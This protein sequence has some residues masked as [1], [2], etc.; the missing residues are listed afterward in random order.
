MRLRIINF[1]KAHPLFVNMA[2]SIARFCLR[3]WGLFVPVQ[4]K[5]MLFASYGGRKFDDS[6]KAIYEEV[7]RRP[8]F[9][10]WRLV[11]AFAEPE[12][13]DLPR[14]EKVKIDTPAFFH[15]LLYSRVW[16]SNSGMDRG[17]KLK[18]RGTV[19]VE[20]WHGSVYKKGCGEEHENTIGG[21]K[22]Q[23]HTGPKDDE[24][25][26][27]V[28]SAVD[29]FHFQRLFHATEA[30]FLRCGFPRNDELVRATAADMTAAR[31]RVGVPEGKLAILY[32][33]TWRE[34]TV[35]DRNEVYCA[36]PI[37][38]RKWEKLL[39]ERYMLLFRA[40]Y[41][42]SA[43]L[44]LEENSFVRNVSDYPAINDLYL[45]S[46]ILISDYS[47]SFIDY[48]V[49]ERPMLCFAYD[50]E[51]YERR[52][53]LYLDPNTELPCRVDRDEDALL[54]SIL[55]MDHGNMCRRTAG[56][57]QK[58]AEYITGH[59]SEAVV[60]EILRRLRKPLA[61]RR[62]TPIEKEPPH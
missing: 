61:N 1:L 8:E 49:L 25:I 26:R 47:S 48:S 19:K 44:N 62:E 29:L 9:A 13:F 50:L 6:P 33:P 3:I 40:H 31:Q 58:H 21:K 28:Q 17:I 30:S 22:A 11:W 43:A 55:T 16:V 14:G 46:D 57:R 15:A 51:E 12:N 27:C 32:M 2:W 23:L 34:Y 36:P 41:A 24:T 10:D 38:L 18:R 59:G 42:V 53:G 5:T 56:F 7:C 35:N 4:D 20:T 37:D 45:A 39:G 60:D 54:E 52:R